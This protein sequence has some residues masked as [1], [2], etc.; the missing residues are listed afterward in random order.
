MVMI[1][2]FNSFLCFPPFHPTFYIRFFS[3]SRYTGPT[4]SFSCFIS[5]PKHRF[6]FH[7]IEYCGLAVSTAVAPQKSRIE[8]YKKEPDIQSQIFVT[9]CAIV[10]K[11][12]SL[13]ASNPEDR[14][15][16]ITRNITDKHNFRK[17][18]PKDC[19]CIMSM[20]KP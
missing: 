4:H 5:H 12:S 14:G 9:N 8:F 2:G 15:G 18:G 19:Q 13:I 10:T 3:P 7:C 11:F 20:R 6:S 1:N 16:K 17:Q